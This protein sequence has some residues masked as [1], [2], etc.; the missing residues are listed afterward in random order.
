MIADAREVLHPPAADHHLR[1]LLQVVTLSGD[2]AKTISLIDEV[3]YYF[4]LAWIAWTGSMSVAALIIDSPKISEQGLDAPQNS[5]K[6]GLHI[7]SQRDRVGIDQPG[8]IGKENTD[9]E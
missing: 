2:V 1:V 7:G 4:V 9:R 3:L 6:E 5:R 8:K